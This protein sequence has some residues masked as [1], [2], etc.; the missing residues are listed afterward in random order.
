M[1]REGI[2]QAQFVRTSIFRSALMPN[3][4]LRFQMVTREWQH[5]FRFPAGAFGLIAVPLIQCPQSPLAC[6]GLLK[7]CRA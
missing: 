1:G 4:F 2:R 5:F 3:R 6:L 7:Y